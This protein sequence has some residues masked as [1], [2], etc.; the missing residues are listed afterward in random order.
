MQPWPDF[1]Y[2]SVLQFEDVLN[3]PDAKEDLRKLVDPLLEDNYPID[4]VHKV[5]SFLKND[6]EKKSK[7]YINNSNWNKILVLILVAD[8]PTC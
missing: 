4:S 5:I 2:T 6:G 8:G 1:Y 3:Q 7:N